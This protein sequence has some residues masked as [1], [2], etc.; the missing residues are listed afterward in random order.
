MTPLDKALGVDQVDV[1][2]IR[3]WPIARLVAYHN[4]SRTHSPEQ[5][6]QIKASLMEFGW[7]NPVLADAMG[8]VAGHGR[9]EAAT[10]L[11]RE[12]KQI[13]FPG[14]VV[15]PIGYVPVVDCTG[16]SD[17]QR[18]AYIIA[19]NKLAENAGWDYGALAI[20]IG[21]L[22]DAGFD[23]DLLGF[24]DD[25]LAHILG[26]DAETDL[27]ELPEGDKDPFE[28]MSFTLHEDQA[29]KVREALALA[30]RMGPFEDSPNENSNGNA[31]NRICEL[32]VMQNGDGE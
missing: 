14:G 4:N 2:Q 25:E 7:T 22:D 20:E 31:L 15:I 13:I 11:Y 10:E 6:R 28:K 32:F 21:D 27:P 16:W 1:P 18:R 19:D 3:L 30:K 24:D 29:D 17:E 5:I 12:G 8:V 26:E 23:V 9:T